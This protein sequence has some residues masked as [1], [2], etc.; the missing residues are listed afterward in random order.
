MIKRLLS[1]TL[2]LT[3][4]STTILFSGNLPV[5]SQLTQ[6]ATAQ[7]AVAKKPI[8]LKL[9]QSKK[10]AD[11]KGFKLIPVTKVTP[12]DE[13]VYSIAASNISNTPISKLVINQ[14]IRSGTTYVLNSATPIKSADLTFSIDGGKT[15][16]AKPIIDKKP[17]VASQYTNVRWAFVGSIAPKSQSNLSYEVQIR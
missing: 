6:P 17:A 2:A 9:T 12:G 15:Y 13:I 8:V 16:T 4:L 1:A 5:I 11:K 14:K 3:A 7:T 10:I